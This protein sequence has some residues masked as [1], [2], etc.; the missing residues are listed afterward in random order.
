MRLKRRRIRRGNEDTKQYLERSEHAQT[1][2][3][4]L[5]LVG[6][7]LSSLLLSSCFDIS[8]CGTLETCEEMLQRIKLSANV[9]KRESGRTQHGVQKQTNKSIVY[10]WT[11]LNNKKGWDAEVNLEIMNYFWVK[12]ATVSYLGR[13]TL[14][15]FVKF[16]VLE[17]RQWENE[18]CRSVHSLW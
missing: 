7:V 16:N 14:D 6:L 9:D 11:F 15:S 3:F 13:Q 1:F 17:S 8:S 2:F 12:I 18:P 4:S 5:T 10:F